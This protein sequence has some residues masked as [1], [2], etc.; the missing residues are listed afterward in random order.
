MGLG[1]HSMAIMKLYSTL[2]DWWPLLSPVEDYAEEAGHYWR[3]LTKHARRPVRALLEFGCGGGNNAFHLKRL[4]AEAAGAKQ[5]GASQPWATQPWAAVLHAESGAQSGAAVAQGQS[6]AQSG[7]PTYVGMPQVRL[8]LT[9][10]SSQMLAVSQRTNPECEHA[11]GDMRRLRLHDEAGA[12]RVFDA[13]FIHDAIMYI[14]GEKDLRRTMETAIVHLTP[15][16]VALLVPD[17]TRETWAASTSHGGRDG[18]GRGLRYLSW[19]FDPDPADSQYTVEMVYV[20]READGRVHVE[21]ERHEHGLFPEAR[22]LGLMREAGFSPAVERCDYA[23]GES[24]R[25]FVGVRV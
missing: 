12:Q 19:S 4:M 3:I 13:V 5:P 21:H 14:T 2:A 20:L 6:G 16:G 25:C 15:G 11:V 7:V 23:G 9:D 24:A 17:C 1:V 18:E 22:W 8:T 10:V